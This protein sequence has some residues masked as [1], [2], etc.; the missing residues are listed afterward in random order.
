MKTNF[1]LGVIATASLL[2]VFSCSKEKE[3]PKE[4][5]PKIETYTMTIVAGK[6]EIGSKALSSDEGSLS[7]TWNAGEI[8]TVYN[9]TK[10]A[11]LEGYLEAQGSGTSTTLSGQLTGIVEANDELTLN[12]LDNDYSTQDGT[13]DFISAN[14]DFATADAK[15]KSVTDGKIVTTSDAN[16]IHQQVIVEF[17]LKES[18]GTEIPG[19]VKSLVVSMDGTTINVTPS[20][21][22]EKLYVAIPA[23][24]NGS[25]SLNAVDINGAP[26]SYNIAGET[27]ENGKYYRY[28]VEMDCV[29]MNYG[30]LRAAAQLSVVPKITLG[31]D[32]T[33]PKPYSQNDLADACICING[34]ETIVLNN[35]S[36]LGYRDSNDNCDRIFSVN[37]G[38]SLV[39]NGPGSL[40][41]GS[42][43][44]GG[45]IFNSGGSIVI[46]DVDFKGSSAG[47]GGAIYNSP[48]GVVTISGATFT[49]NYAE[50]AGGAIYNEGTLN[51]SGTIVASANTSTKA[52][53]PD[54]VY[55]A[56][57]AVI[58]VTGAFGEGTMIGVTLAGGTGVFTSGYSTWNPSVN[59]AS[60]F[61]SDASTLK[62]SSSANEVALTILLYNNVSGK[63]YANLSVL[64]EETGLLSA[65]GAIGQIVLNANFTE[66]Q[67][68]AS[69][70]AISY[71]YYSTDPQGDPVELSALI[72]VPDAA[73]SGA[74]L[75]GICLTNHGTIAKNAQCPT[76]SSQFEGVFSWKNYAIVMPDY[77]G[78]GVSSDRPQGYLDAENTA[79][80]SID[81]YLAAVQ[82]LEDRGASIPDNL[83]SFGYSQGGFNSMANLKYVSKH[84]ELEI[85]F[86]KVFCGGSPFDVMTTWNAYTNG[87][88]HNS[89]AFVPMTIVSINETHKLGISYSDL[90]KGALLE[91][92]RNW[93]LSKNYT[94][95]EISDLL[96]ANNQ[97]SV[98]DILNAD[99]IAGTGDV[100]N[101]IRAVCEGYSL[102]SGW[103]PPSGTKMFLYHSE[104]DDTVP[105][106]NLKAMT[107]FLD[108]AAPGSYNQYHAANGGHMDAVLWFI[109]NIIGEW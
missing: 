93:I 108:V 85:S 15:V 3:G 89:L 106:E 26:R 83:Y 13:L 67:Q 5:N 28:D 24:S 21:A 35:H 52:G 19:G 76:K 98:S 50:D 66:Q 109:L 53:T 97:N 25:L 47:K 92:W 61:R 72:Y 100:F 62:P 33:Y 14:C 104:G 87:A 63:A 88:F 18:D 70:T 12:F 16:F 54:N 7:V 23:V 42:Q 49:D 17:T 101:A 77:Y 81:A 1:L 74:E 43:S 32:I 91:N 55:L 2:V 60:V 8:V 69:V 27:F 34:N 4:R 45:A 37:E 20:S 90:F 22:M 44:M 38:K 78:F 40:K 29:V 51:M 58:T 84:P 10:D 46:N 86:K 56:D 48:K 79:H 41:G 30:E 71:T 68:K 82:L 80:N 11:D 99:M 94:T 59:P 96:K 9:K 103:T 105:Y 64:L 73:F 6:G 102:T 65:L 75:T 107:D 39:L 57:G 31:A 36:L 95:N